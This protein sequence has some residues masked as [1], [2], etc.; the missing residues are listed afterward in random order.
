MWNAIAD[1]AADTKRAEREDFNK[2]RSRRTKLCMVKEMDSSLSSKMTTTADYAP[3]DVEVLIDIDVD[4]E[5][6]S[7]Y[8]AD[9][10]TSNGDDSDD[11]YNNI[12]EKL[13]LDSNLLMH[14]DHDTNRWYVRNLRPLHPYTN[15]T[16][17]ETCENLLRMNRKSSLSKTT[18]NEILTEFSKALPV[19]HNLPTSF[20][21]LLNCMRILDLFCKKVL[22]S[23]CYQELDKEKKTCMNSSCQQFQSSKAETHIVFSGD[24]KRLLTYIVS[25]TLKEID[26]YKI[27]INDDVFLKYDDDI[28]SGEKYQNLLKSQSDGL[29]ITLIIHPDG[30]PLVKTTKLSLWALSA[31]IVELHPQLRQRRRNM[32]LLSA[33]I[34]NGKPD[35]FGWLNSVV[36]QLM[37]LKLRGI[38][39]RTETNEVRHYSCYFHGIVGDLPGLAFVLNFKGHTGYFSCFFCF[40]EGIRNG[41]MLFP[42]TSPLLLRTSDDWCRDSEEAVRKKE[43]V[44]GHHGISPIA[45]L[46]DGD[47]PNSIMIDYLHASLLRHVKTV[48]VELTSRLSKNDCKKLDELLK[49]QKFPHFFNR[50]L[51]G[52]LDVSYV[53]ATEWRSLVLYALLPKFLPFFDDDIVAYLSLFVCALRCLHGS[54]LNQISRRS[55]EEI[56]AV[57]IDLYLK[58][59]SEYFVDQETLTCHLHAHYPRQFGRHGNVSCAATFSFEDFLGSVGS[60][61]HG[62]RSIGAQLVLYYN[63]DVF[64]QDDVIY[65]DG[66]VDYSKTLPVDCIDR[67]EVVDEIVVQCHRRLCN[68]DN[69]N[70]CISV[71]RRH[72][73]RG[74]MYH[75]LL[76]NKRQTSVSY[77]VADRNN[78]DQLNFG[79][80][81]LFFKLKDKMFSLI[82]SY[83][84]KHKFSDFFINTRFYNNICKVIDLYFFVVQ[85]IS[86]HVKRVVPVQSILRHCIVFDSNDALVVTPVSRLD[87]HD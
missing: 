87:E 69:V 77:F 61:Y 5:D 28:V 31:S 50:K 12:F 66:V 78:N 26:G 3:M 2:R 76:Y 84:E 43:N 62:S 38:V 53:K 14:D 56:S 74:F 67:F 25:R 8:L 68:C 7:D 27:M 59:H 20:D 51:R 35:V 60:S 65:E 13:G 54:P 32:M 24:I 15:V 73:I 40:L 29:F 11:I 23:L 10:C 58:F 39:I 41:K 44:L 57:L 47:L 42:Y 55:R 18:M 86:C 19:P 79:K 71:F 6:K 85:K 9:I 64:L 75:S 1:V 80:I 49:S 52:V 22:C 37:D 83:E 36:E 63:I 72:F 16:T 21:N 30:L 70:S 81:L 34:G 4:P 45:D 33:C 17:G 48:V 82:E 46:F